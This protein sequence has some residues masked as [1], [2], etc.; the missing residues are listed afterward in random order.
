MAGLTTTLLKNILLQLRDSNF[1]AATH[2][3]AGEAAQE[4]TPLP[5][6]TQYFVAAPGDPEDTERYTKSVSW[7]QP[8]TIYVCSRQLRNKTGENA[9]IGIGTRASLDTI[10]DDCRNVLLVESP[11]DANKPATG[12]YT[13][14]TGVKT[15]LYEGVDYMEPQEDEDGKITD[16]AALKL[17]Y[18]CFEVR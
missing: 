13:T 1:S 7:I 10:V 8:I 16:V 3:K 14:Q 11:Y 9:T 4:F 17:K 5:R 6:A 2:F 12:G 18:L 15:V